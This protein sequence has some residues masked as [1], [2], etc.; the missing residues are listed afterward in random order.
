MSDPRAP[1]CTPA[2]VDAITVTSETL[3]AAAGQ[4]Q[5]TAATLLPTTGAACSLGTAVAV[6][7]DEKARTL[8]FDAA[9]LGTRLDEDTLQLRCLP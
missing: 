4:I 3:P 8:V 7:A 5:T 6:A 9:A 1:K 2:P